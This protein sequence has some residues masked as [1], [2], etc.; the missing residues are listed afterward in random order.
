MA[1]HEATFDAL[2][3]RLWD[4]VEA[5]GSYPAEVRIV[6]YHDAEAFKAAL[7]DRAVMSFDDWWDTID[8]F[9]VICHHRDVTVR[10]VYD[11]KGATPADRAEAA[12]RTLRKDE[13][14]LDD[15]N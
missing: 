11:V 7:G 1:V 6:G 14:P 10:L 12:A 2:C 9:R 13:D 3:R 4:E 15:G 8:A 5:W